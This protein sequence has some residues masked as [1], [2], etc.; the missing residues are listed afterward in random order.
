[1]TRNNIGQKGRR[2]NFLL[3]AVFVF[4]GIIFAKIFYVSY[5]QHEKLASS[6]R[7]QQERSRNFNIKRG[8][9]LARSSNGSY[10]TL[11]AKDNLPY[12][13]VVPKQSSNPSD[14]A[15]KLS[16]ILAEFSED[17]FLKLLSKRNDPF[18]LIDKKIS[19]KTAKLVEGLNLPEVKVGRES[20]RVYPFNDTLAHS[21]GFLGF[22]GDNRSGQY[23]LEGY[24]DDLLKKE[25][26]IIL[27]VDYE[28]QSIIES[29]LT[30]ILK[31]WSAPSGTIIVQD[32]NSGAILAIA[33]SPSFD[34]NN[35]S[36]YSLKRF[37]NPA[38][39]EMFEPGST[40]KTITM[41]AGIDTAKVSPTTVYEDGG[42]LNIGSYTI[43]N[44]D[45]K[46]HGIKTMT[47]VLEKS[48]NT[49][50]V[51]VQN[52]L[53]KD[54]FLNHVV[55]FGFGK[56]T[57]IDL[58]GE[59][60][61]DV[62]NLYS[63]RP[64]NF[65][66][67]SFGQGIAVTPIQL[68]TA[69]SAVANGGKLMRPYM[70]DEIVYA[71][72]RKEKTRSQIVGVPITEKT[73]AQLKNMLVSV[74]KHGFDKARVPGYDIAAKTG[75]AQIAKAGGYSEDFIHDMVGFAPAFSP[76]FTILIKLDKPKGIRFAADSL[77]PTFREISKFLLNH[78]KIPPS[79]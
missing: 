11:A 60:S 33:S 78:Y 74:V 20:A 69:Y 14:T 25:A 8:E 32:P 63:G 58:E 45:E 66:T 53:G 67:A 37:I 21:L 15:K 28:V 65:A 40:F 10:L 73:S 23:G 72:G 56:K 49:G 5:F 38:V 46:A 13:Y 18:E 16:A 55:N 68:I 3:L 6:A 43:R 17:T 39:Q 19:E 36:S 64:I 61:G 77:S 31:K 12:V 4:F 62:A 47:Q 59:I 71:D 79:Q 50:A 51:F 57:E 52:L 35:Y 34:P 24:Y 1:M 2:I 76:K 30:S 48:L 7:S 70:V 75:T 41:A 29:S 26:S 9:I 22:E 54:L 44:Y 27:T 42:V